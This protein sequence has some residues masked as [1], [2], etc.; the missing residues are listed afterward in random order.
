M[1]PFDGVFAG[2]DAL[3]RNCCAFYLLRLALFDDDAPPRSL[4][5]EEP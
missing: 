5:V 2:L 1:P 4:G 3:D